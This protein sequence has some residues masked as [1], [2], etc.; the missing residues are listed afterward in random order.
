MTT[1]VLPKTGLV[2]PDLGAMGWATEIVNGF[3]ALENRIGLEGS[4]DPNGHVAGNWEGQSYFDTATATF[5]DCNS[6]GPATGIGAAQWMRRVPAP[7]YTTDTG[8]LFVGNLLIQFGFQNTD[9]TGFKTVNFANPYNNTNGIL[10]ANATGYQGVT[11]INA[12]IFNITTTSI[13]VLTTLTL[14]TGQVISSLF[15]WLVI[16]RK[17]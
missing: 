15:Y 1:V 9:G 7:T 12:E 8:V 10:F 14:N 6:A 16:G 5:W 17:A 2:K 4:G 13:R 11:R 3:Q